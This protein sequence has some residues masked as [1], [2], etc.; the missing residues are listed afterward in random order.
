LA[1]G[2]SEGE[3]LATMVGEEK[4]IKPFAAIVE[5]IVKFLLSQLA[6]NP[7]IATNVL[8]KTVVESIQE[9]FKTEAQ[10]GPILKEETS[11]DHKITNSL[12]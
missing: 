1:E 7:F 11:Q 6:V 5:G 4:C 3:V 8:K 2:I 12:R 9:G 10:E